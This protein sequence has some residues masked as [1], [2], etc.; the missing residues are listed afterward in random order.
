[1]IR[2]EKPQTQKNNTFLNEVN[3]HIDQIRYIDILMVISILIFKYRHIDI[4]SEKINI[5]IVSNLNYLI[6]P[7]TSVE[8]GDLDSV[9]EGRA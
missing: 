2:F 7:I 4:F 8:C 3:Q 6:S 1:M 5:D 9:K